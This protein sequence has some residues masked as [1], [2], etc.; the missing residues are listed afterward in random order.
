VTSTDAA[1][2]TPV[3]STGAPGTAS[4]TIPAEPAPSATTTNP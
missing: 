3:S 4:S 2:S 1:S